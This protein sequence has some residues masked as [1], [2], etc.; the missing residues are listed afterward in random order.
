M[1]DTVRTDKMN[2]A[3]HETDLC[4]VGGGLSGMCAA[5]AAAR[6]GIRVV[7]MQDRPVLGGNASS[8]IRVWVRGAKGKYNRETGIISELEEENVYRN[9]ELNYS[10]WDSVM[11]EKVRNEKNIELILNCSC[12]D[13]ETEK[14]GEKTRI[15][16]VT[17][18]QLTTYTW[19]TVKAKY[20]A[21]CSGDSVLA[22]LSGAAWRAGRESRYEYGETI[23]HETADS[24]TMG[25][26]CLIQARETGRPVRFVAPDWAYVFCSDSDFNSDSA[27]AGREREGNPGYLRRTH[28][29]G[30]DG[31]NFWWIE[32]GGDADSIR[33]T[34]LMRDELLKIA[35]GIWDYIKNRGGEPGAE[36]WDLTWVGFLPGKRESRRYIGEYVM[37]EKD[38]EAGGH[39]TDTVAYGGWPMDDHHPAG[40]RSYA[41]GYPPSALFPAPSPYGIPYR[42]LYGREVSNLFF[43]GRNVSVTHAALSST[44]VM[45]TCSLLGQA[46]GTAASM[47]VLLNETPHGIYLRHIRKLQSK[48]MDQGCMLPGF[49]R[50]IPSLTLG[51][52]LNLSPEQTEVLF[53]GKERPDGDGED[54]CVELP[55][56]FELVMDFG[57]EEDLGTLRL[58][59]DPDFSRESVSDNLKM[60]VFAQT[61]CV[62][63]DFR[64]VRAASTLVRGFE[65]SLD[66]LTVYET[67]SC[68]NSLVR[69]PL[70]RR[71]RT[72]RVRFRETWGAPSVRLYSADVSR[73]REDS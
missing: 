53:N 36:N 32:L 46:A 58:V 20:F 2:M 8:E 50:R 38:I 56:G 60:R 69:I 37:T 21:D 23:G 29:L 62:G 73:L 61:S 66:G 12:C 59:F 43:A 54:N 51:A 18:W 31:S 13:A 71:G 24:K 72:L 47:C 55:L 57:R 48:L 1:K 41:E 11:W 28:K 52:S 45:A 30:T 4:V 42:V 10:V 39:F 33:D 27:V 15:V 70:N 26:S 14:D 34:E 9:P 67:S 5:I 64:P 7:L 17:G 65:V 3:C 35:Y 6:E 40:F 22:T 49:T 44:R 25:M 16:S 19:H 68:R 63:A